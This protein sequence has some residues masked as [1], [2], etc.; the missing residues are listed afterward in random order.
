[1][2]KRLFYGLFIFFAVT[3][4][5][6]ATNYT[7]AN[8]VNSSNL[9]SCGGSTSNWSYSSGTF[10]C[11]YSVSLSAGDT[12]TASS[13]KILSVANG[14]TLGGSN[15]IGS[16]SSTISLTSANGGITISGSNNTVYGDISGAATGVSISGAT[17]TGNVSSA[18]NTVS[19]TNS[20]INGSVTSGGGSGILL[21][22]TAVIGDV[23]STNNTVQTSGGSITGNIEAGGAG[24][25]TS[26]TNITATTIKVPNNTV[27]ITGG[28]ISGAITTSGGNGVQLTN[29]T[30]TSGS[31]TTNN[32]AVLISGSHVGSSSNIVPIS[33]G[34]TVRVQSS[35]TVYASI[36]APDY[37]SPSSPTIIKDSTSII[38]GTCSPNYGNPCT[39]IPVDC[40]SYNTLFGYGIIGSTG[41]VRGQNS[42]INNIDIS[43]TVTD[44]T[45]PTP[46]GNLASVHPT[47]PSIVPST[48]PVFSSSVD[49]LNQATIAAGTYNDISVSGKEHGGNTPYT[50][51]FT[52]GTYYIKKLT[53]GGQSA[54][55]YVTL[56]P[57][58]YYID[59]LVMENNAEIRL[60][61]T[62]EV[63]IYIGT[64]ITGD[65]DLK[66]NSSG[67]VANLKI[68]LYDGVNV[69]IGNY[70]NGTSTLSFNGMI[71]S[72]YTNTSIKF[73]NNN[74][75]QGAIV[76]A[77]SVNVG[78]NTDLFYDSNVQSSLFTSVGCQGYIVT[79]YPNGANSGTVPSTSGT[80]Y[81][82]GS[83][84][85][86]SGNTGNL[87]KTGATFNGWNTSAD[88]SGTDYAPGS[89]FTISSNV[90]L[91]AKWLSNNAS[92]N[93]WETVRTKDTASVYTKVV[94]STFTEVVGTTDGSVFDGVVCV[95]VV[96]ANGVMLAGGGYQCKDINAA[97]TTFSWT[98]TEAS[99]N[100]RI[101]INSKSGTTT[102]GVV[103]A[104]WSGYTVSDSTDW[105][106]I[107]PSD[108][109]VSVTPNPAKA[110]A[111]FTLSASH[112]TSGYNGTTS[113]TTSVSNTNCSTKSGFLSV[114]PE[115][116]TFATQSQTKTLISKD[117]GDLSLTIKDTTWT[118]I[119]Q[120]VGCVQDSSSNTPDT[121]GRVGCD[122][123]KS[124]TIKV[125]PYDINATKT[126]TDPIW[127]YRSVG[128]LPQMSFDFTVSATRPPLGTETSAQTLPNYSTNCYAEDTTVVLN[129]SLTPTSKS[130]T[131]TS[132]IKIVPTDTAIVLTPTADKLS[133]LVP[134]SKFSSGTANVGLLINSDKGT[135]Y[136]PEDVMTLNVTGWTSSTTNNTYDTTT[137]QDKLYFLYGRIGAP[138]AMLNFNIATP[139]IVRVYAQVYATGSGSLPGSYTWVKVPGSANWWINALDNSVL[140]ELSSALPRASSTLGGDNTTS[141]LNGITT[142]PIGITGGV[143]QVS[144]NM[145]GAQN[146]DQQFKLHFAVPSYLSFTTQ[147]YSYTANSDC[148]QHPCSTIEIFGTDT[149]Q[150]YGAGDKKNSN[151]IESV[152]K[153]K[154]A[155]KVNW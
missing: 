127:A 140:T 61:N 66:I 87:S 146:I 30:M 102:N 89:M 145:S 56:A 116:M 101:V 18:N 109:T 60:T 58:S 68:Y 128:G 50:S 3:S 37:N 16:Q 5:A 46:T 49:L 135:T 82:S 85:T 51:D 67:S 150:W 75:I 149:T 72:P 10:T 13:S 76:S 151:A 79:Y 38:Y 73:G 90:G 4:Q 154:R 111:A 62:G 57:G 94:G 108:I 44:P 132:D 142:T 123:E 14:I 21:T 77:G 112:T 126:T 107:K 134:L 122:I 136:T 113:I 7:L 70:N 55:N 139:Q 12:I 36:T 42:T 92:F 64:S 100:A 106:A 103:P 29:V 110:G 104:N 138:N 65:N 120:Y 130:L 17:V 83:T 91:F 24:L 45:T 32:V 121:T 129:A 11:N 26:N 33:S 96:D 81:V 52:G 48:F 95:S 131:S 86:V 35:S 71:Y 8:N 25:I 23:K 34:N 20:T 141:T 59:Q 63:K 41:F 19:I 9:P 118:V 152:P 144:V 148:S 115:T 53:I 47:F 114:E 69:D 143:G 117:V 31:I 93:S 133:V 88:G 78:Q 15:T 84:V 22:N 39:D 80:M 98:L 28:T 40:N 124:T 6:F 54:A 137:T 99:K 43:G 105:F 2:G 1:M 27:S 147:T 125:I 153:G 155:P 97:S 119:D 74:N